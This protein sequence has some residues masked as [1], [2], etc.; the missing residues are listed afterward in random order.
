MVADQKSDS[1]NAGKGLNSVHIRKV[2]PGGFAE[3]YI[4]DLEKKKGT[5]KWTIIIEANHSCH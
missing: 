3:E 4:E 1:E 5:L 2:Q